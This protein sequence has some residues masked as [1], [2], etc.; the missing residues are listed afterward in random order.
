MKTLIAAILMFSFMNN[1]FARDH[2]NRGWHDTHWGEGHWVHDRH[3]GRLGW[4]WVIG[5]DW[6]FYSHPIAQPSYVIVQADPQPA[7]VVVQ[8][9]PPVQVVSA[10]A[11]AISA[12]VAPP[13]PAPTVVAPMLYYCQSKGNYYP[14]VMTCNEGWAQVPAGAPPPPQL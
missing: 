9:P 3:L 10:P 7:R 2:F 4:W 5:S 11:Q 13:K 8:A 14:Q 12:P 6:H 1:A